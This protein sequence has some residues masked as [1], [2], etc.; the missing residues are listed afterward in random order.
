MQ[1]HLGDE[2]LKHPTAP[3]SPAFEAF[4]RPQGQIITEYDRW[5]QLLLYPS[6]VAARGRARSFAGLRRADGTAFGMAEC[7]YIDSHD[8]DA[9]AA[10]QDDRFCITIYE[11]VAYQM[12]DLVSLALACPAFFKDIG[13]PKKEDAGRVAARE[14]PAGYG[15]FR[16]DLSEPL[17]VDTELAH[18][19]CPIRSQ[20]ALFFTGLA[21]DAIWTHELAHAFMGHV[22]YAQSHLG[23]RALNETPQGDSDLR[24]MP[25]EAEADRFACATL[26]QASFA[27]LPYLPR[28]LSELSTDLRIKAGFVVSALITWF[29]AF[30]Q[31]IDRTYDGIDPYAQ[32]SHPPPLARLHLSF[33]GGRDMLKNLGQPVPQVQAMTFEA[34]AEL[35]TL[36]D[37]KD[38]FS[39]LHPARSFD[40]AAN[41]FVAN[42]KTIIGVTYRAEADALEPL[43]YSQPT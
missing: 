22:D 14:K 18:P 8:S 26:V 21:L 24:Q 12:L 2:I 4:A 6:L 19:R 1:D 33:D 16:K 3:P 27:P 30:Q 17:R 37:T 20:A 41:E 10:R 23:L 39:I 29:W 11:A 31:R 25:L 13:D 7:H 40:T 15:F 34:M 43:R 28:D 5:G 36:A 9:Q 42:I 35:E 32:G 38:W